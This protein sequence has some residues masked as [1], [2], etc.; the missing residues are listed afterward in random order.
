MLGFRYQVLGARFRVRYCVRHKIPLGT[1]FFGSFLGGST[2]VDTRHE[3]QIE[4]KMGSSSTR[5]VFP[6]PGTRYQVPT[7]KTETTYRGELGI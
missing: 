1:L 2:I 6:T 4:I 5:F 3:F 7:P